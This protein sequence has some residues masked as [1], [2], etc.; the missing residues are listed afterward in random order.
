MISR[1][2]KTDNLLV[3]LKH[4]DKQF[5]QIS[6]TQKFTTSYKSNLLEVKNCLLTY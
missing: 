2:I 4:S 5:T 1:S 3:R 6:Q